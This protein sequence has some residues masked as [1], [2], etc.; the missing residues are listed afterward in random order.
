MFDMTALPPPPELMTKH[1]LHGWSVHF[2]PFSKD[3]RVYG[4]PM[5]RIHFNSPWFHVGVSLTPGCRFARMDGGGSWLYT[6]RWD[7]EDCIDCYQRRY[8]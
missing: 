7:R 3:V 4:A 6:R 8:G 1:F 5:W 2:C